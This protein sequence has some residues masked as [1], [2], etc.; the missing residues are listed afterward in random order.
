MT[1][2]YTATDAA[3][4]NR[5]LQA[6]GSR[7]T[8]T[9][10]EMNALSSNEA[11]QMNLVYTAYRDQLLRMAQWDCALKFDNLIW[12]TS[13]PGTPENT[14][15]FTV[16]WQRGQPAPPW[17]YE[18][19]YPDDC[20]RACWII[21]TNQTGFAGGVPIS[22]AVTGGYA[23]TY[24]N[25]PIIY[26]VTTDQFRA[27]SGL[28]IVDGGSGYQVGDTVIL[29]TDTLGYNFNAGE[30]PAGVVKI[31]VA[32]I[33]G[34]GAILTATLTAFDG[35]QVAQNGF[36]FSVPTYDLVQVQTS[37]IGTGASVTV[38][39]VGQTQF[40]ARVILTNQEFAMM[41][42][43]RQITDPNVFDPTFIEA[44]AFVLGAATCMAL[45]GDKPLANSLVGLAN[46]KIIQ[47]R[48]VDGNEGLTVNDV[49]PDFVRARGIY[50]GQY[51][52]GPDQGFQ[53]GDLWG[54]W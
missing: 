41:A 9:A 53:W 13:T 11:I 22:N 42:Y 24:F 25:A 35:T 29:G 17:N 4:I 10:S 46:A 31:T 34:S 14:S 52:W 37:G 38:S 39:G 5:G 12:L 7:T 18:Y 44:F 15:P 43:I 36:L 30:V 6:Y 47:A 23:T 16:T 21:P 48:S 50:W 51:G 1:Y 33:D 45:T 20:L 27:A 8:V 3:I 32:T 49:T 40:S 26:K 2:T 19:L 54:T 28:A